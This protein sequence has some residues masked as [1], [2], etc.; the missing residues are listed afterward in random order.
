MKARITKVC[1]DECL[2]LKS[3]VLQ[4]ESLASCFNGRGEGTLAVIKSR[5]DIRWHGRHDELKAQRHGRRRTPCLVAM[6]LLTLVKKCPLRVQRNAMVWIIVVKPTMLLKG[7]CV[8]HWQLVWWR[9]LMLSV[10]LTE[11]SHVGELS[12]AVVC[13]LKRSNSFCHEKRL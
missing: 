11:T 2:S 9:V 12:K 7:Q 8:L 10:C 1:I 6:P 5:I 4:A 3:S 13:I